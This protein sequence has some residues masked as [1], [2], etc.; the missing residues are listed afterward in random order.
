MPHPVRRVKGRTV[1]RESRAWQHVRRQPVQRSQTSISPLDAPAAAAPL[2][3]EG[4][5]IP[6]WVWLAASGAVGLLLWRGFSHSQATPSSGNSYAVPGTVP[7][8]GYTTAPTGGGYGSGAGYTNAPLASPSGGG[9]LKTGLA[10]AGGVAAGMMVDEMLHR[11]QGAGTDQLS[12]LQQGIFNPPPAD[13]AANEL[14]RSSV[15]FGHGSDWDPGSAGVD[16]GN[17]GTDDGAWD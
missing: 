13:D 16:L 8:A 3:A 12:G 14:E 11:R 5:G 17:G 2:R 1:L 9:L 15:D 10:V 6:I 4:A 7:T